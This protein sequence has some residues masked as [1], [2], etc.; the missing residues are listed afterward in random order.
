MQWSQNPNGILEFIWG[1]PLELLYRNLTRI[2]LL[3]DF[4]YNVNSMSVIYGS[5]NQFW[6]Q[7]QQVTTSFD[8]RFPVLA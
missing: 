7:W 4:T 8:W 3:S 5:C 2:D 6:Y 1:Y